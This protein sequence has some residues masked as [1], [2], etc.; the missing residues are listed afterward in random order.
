MNISD[1]ALES[2]AKAI[3]DI[4]RERSDR[5]Y[6]DC[7]DGTKRHL[8]REA[9]AVLEAAAPHMWTEA[10]AA[11]LEEAAAE[12][13]RLPYARPDSPDRAEYERVLAVRRGNAD[14]WLK[15]RAAHIR[16]QS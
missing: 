4:D 2:G 9:R 3:W 14:A 6:E 12:L 10:K 11:A 15:D 8:R 1:E 5:E 16:D 7:R 13:A